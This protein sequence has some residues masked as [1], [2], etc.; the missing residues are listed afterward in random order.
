VCALAF[1]WAG[2][3][4]PARAAWSGSGIKVKLDLVGGVSSVHQG[5]TFSFE[6]TARNTGGDNQTVTITIE[7]D[8]PSSADQDIRSWDATVPPGGSVS[9][10]MSAVTSQWFSDLGTFTLVAKLDGIPTGN[11]L[12]F[13]VTPPTVTVPV[14]Q[15]VTGASG[16][17]TV[18]PS[19][20][21]TSHAEGAAWGD[22]NGDGYP[23][24]YVPIRDQPAQLWIFDPGTR[25]FSEQA[26]AWKVT[27]PGGAGVSATFADFDNDGDPDLYV[28]N[29]AID[30]NGQPTLQGN[31]LYRNEFAQGHAAFT[32]ISVSAGVGTQGNGAS[33]SWGD[34][35]G[36]GYLD[37]YAVT[38]DMHDPPI[39]YYQ[40][41]HLFRNE[42]DGTFTDVTCQ[43]LP[44]NDQGSGFCPDPAFGGST[45]S[46]FEAVWIDYDGDG[47]QDLYL[48]Q[49]YYFAL[50]H[51]D[52]N[53]LYRNDGLDQSTGHWK[54]TDVCAGGGGAE[55]LK[56]N[57]M[58][59]AVGDVD[60]DQ[61]PDIAVSNSGYKG[62]NV[63][64]RNDQDG[65]FTEMG[66]TAGIARPDQTATVLAVTWLGLIG[67]GLAFLGF[68]FLLGRWGATRTSTV[69]YVLPVVGIVLGVSV[70]GETI[71]LAVLA[72][73]ALIIGGVALA[74]SG[75]G[76]RRLIGRRAAPV[77][78]EGSVQAGE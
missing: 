63:L 21:G 68:F 69:A 22:V 24:L 46:G 3:A 72:G 4:L 16:L 66:A 59:V 61:W 28:V 70:R 39:T 10:E 64:L 45:G 19:D 2:P 77:A 1:L 38:G 7:L 30:S 43:S 65:T 54:F 26:G 56:I 8:S 47:D 55:C 9:D 31:R 50:A 78:G 17:D 48:A 57:S 40:Q 15:D 12:P 6:V 58:G 49:D 27:N 18:L 44:T 13:S 33:A 75:F 29:D 42:G 76:H 32:D 51:K 53:R 71:S 35:D 52:M 74:N 62:G 37:L 20:A 25:T 41:D 67:S 11:S 34:Y 14:F 60:G 73:M 5:T 36:D 23:D